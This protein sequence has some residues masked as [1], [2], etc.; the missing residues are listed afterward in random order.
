MTESDGIQAIVNHA[1]IKAATVAVM[2][3]READSRLGLD[4]NRPG[5]REVHREINYTPALN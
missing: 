2:V 5:L 4:E 3:L 1:T